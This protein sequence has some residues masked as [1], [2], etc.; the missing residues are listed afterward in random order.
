MRVH[1]AAAPSRASCAA[2]A[3]CVQCPALPKHLMDAAILAGAMANDQIIGGVRRCSSSWSS[4][5]RF[6]A[7]RIRSRR[8]KA[9]IATTMREPTV[10]RCMG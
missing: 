4:I 9:H 8:L 7:W 10:R 1:S 5:L 6:C 2:Y 3:Q